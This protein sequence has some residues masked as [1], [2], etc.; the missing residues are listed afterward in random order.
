VLKKE[1]DDEDSDYRVPTFKGLIDEYEQDK[2][3]SNKG[4]DQLQETSTFKNAKLL[5]D[6]E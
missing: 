2:Y 6:K 1:D 3:R 5:H 4:E